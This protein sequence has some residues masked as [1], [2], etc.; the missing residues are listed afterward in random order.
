[1]AELLSD[2]YVFAE[3]PELSTAKWAGGGGVG[4]EPLSKHPLIPA[5]TLQVSFDE[6]ATADLVQIGGE[7]VHEP[8]YE[9]GRT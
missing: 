4:R 2:L 6:K 3:P 1:V 7:P 8:V 9:I 5:W